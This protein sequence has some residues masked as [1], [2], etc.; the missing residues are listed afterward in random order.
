VHELTLTAGRGSAQAL[1]PY[2]IAPGSRI[3]P[4][5]YLELQTVTVEAD[6]QLPLHGY[7]RSLSGTPRPRARITL[8]KLSAS[9]HADPELD[10]AS[11]I[12][13]HDGLWYTLL[14]PQ[15]NMLL[16]A[17]HAATPAVASALLIVAVKPS[18][19]LSVTPTGM[20]VQVAGIVVPPK[21]RVEIE[22]RPAAGTR[23]ATRRV[24]VES[25]GGYFGT[26]LRLAPGRYWLNANT[27]ADASNV[28]GTSAPIAVDI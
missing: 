6:G 2:A 1:A 21:P 26:T 13:E 3:R 7:L 19:T 20:G 4:S 17:L 16:R 14:A 22:V 11:A 28:A 18:L 9:R 27:H 25:A 12:T 8:Q 23:H 24:N 5:S 15:T 10:L